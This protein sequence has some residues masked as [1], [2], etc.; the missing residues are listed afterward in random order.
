MRS[1]QNGDEY[2]WRK[3]HPTLI[4]GNEIPEVICYERANNGKLIR[5]NFCGEKI[6]GAGFDF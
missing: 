2:R 3:F 4:I 1:S 6:R 5:Y